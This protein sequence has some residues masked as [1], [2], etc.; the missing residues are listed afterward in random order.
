MKRREFLAAGSGVGAVAL[1]GCAGGDGGPTTTTTA[2]TTTDPYSGTLHV[3]TYEP[4]I[5]A[6]SVSPGQWVKDHFEAEYPDATVEWLTPE[7]GVNYFVQ[8]K[9][10]GVTIDADVYVGINPDDLVRVDEQL[11][12]DGLFDT[13]APDEIPNADAVIEDVQFDPHGRVVPYDTGYICLVYDADEVDAPGTFDALL[14]EEYA[15]TLLVQNAQN[16]DPGRAFLLWTVATIG[17]DAYLDYWQG[18]V[19]NGVTILGDWNATY[20]AYSNGERPMVVS[21][22][23]DQVYAHR[24]DEPLQQH[25]IG[26]LNDQGYAT[27]E[28]MGRFAA[29]DSPGLAAAFMDFLLRPATQSQLAVLNVMFPATDHAS[30]PADFT[31]YAQRPPETVMHSYADLQGSLDT[32]VEQWAQRIV[33]G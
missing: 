19:D 9:R 13:L 17:E 27:P 33:Q 1:T 7:T 5:D 20:T 21:Y 23:T 3:A 2:R 15:D 18:L 29:S 25:Q 11:G 12:T 24:Y 22:S 31:T 28:G 32:W 30:P 14:T 6:P 26:F 8:R 4:F 10:A 16:S